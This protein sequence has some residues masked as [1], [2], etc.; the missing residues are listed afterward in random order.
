MQR[1][2]KYFKEG[3]LALLPIVFIFFFIKLIWSIF[4]MFGMKLVEKLIRIKCPWLSVLTA[5][6]IM[7]GLIYL[8]GVALSFDKVKKFLISIEEKFLIKIPFIGGTII[9]TKSVANNNTQ[10]VMGEY[11]SKDIFSP[12]YVTNEINEKW[13]IVFFPTSPVVSTGFTIM[14]ERKKV[15]YLKVEGIRTIENFLSFWGKILEEEKVEIARAIDVIKSRTKTK[16]RIKN[17]ESN[18]GLA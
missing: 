9:F 7:I 18:E 8:L 5:L 2:K 10:V 4:N 6:I 13:I 12:G 15:E 17:G 1:A 14:I 11:P 3:F 16:R